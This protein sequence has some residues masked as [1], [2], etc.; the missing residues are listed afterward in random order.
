MATAEQLYAAF[1]SVCS[2]DE[3][4][5]LLLPLEQLEDGGRGW[6][7]IANAVKAIAGPA[8]DTTDP[9]EVELVPIAPRKAPDGLEIQESEDER[10]TKIRIRGFTA[11]DL[12]VSQHGSDQFL[13][14][15]FAKVTGVDLDTIEWRM[16][17]SDVDGGLALVAE[18]TGEDAANICR[19]VYFEGGGTQQLAGVPVQAWSEVA[20]VLLTEFDSNVARVRCR[21]PGVG[22]LTIGP[23]RAGHLRLHTSNAARENEWKGRLVALAKAADRPLGLMLA[24]RPE[25]AIHAWEA[26]EALKKKAGQHQSTAIAARL[27]SRTTAAGAKQTS[28]S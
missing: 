11:A 18:A 9:Y 15:V 5:D 23:L 2:V 20:R 16:D 22:V 7:A 25:D 26:F 10:P 17:P 27:S 12:C 3:N 13:H 1:R 21:T 28:T 24:L 8:T 6:F 19:T 14:A 4:G